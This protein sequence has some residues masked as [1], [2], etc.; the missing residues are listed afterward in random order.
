VSGIH[1]RNSETFVCLRRSF[2][3]ISSVLLF[4]HCQTPAYQEEELEIEV[5]MTPTPIPTAIHP[6]VAFK[7]KTKP[8]PKSVPVN[9]VFRPD[10][11][12]KSQEITSDDIRR[13]WSKF[14]NFLKD[15]KLTRDDL[16]VLIPGAQTIEEEMTSGDL[17]EASKKISEFHKTI[18]SIT[19]D[20]TFIEKK[21]ERIHQLLNQQNLPEEEARELNA[22]LNVVPRLV[23]EREYEFA[24]EALNNLSEEIL[25]AKR[26]TETLGIEEPTS[27]PTTETPAATN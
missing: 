12:P 9:H 4:T 14:E 13:Q 6:K 11:A 7:V 27:P 17:E 24:N 21:L 16:I 1:L 5:A 18:E 2:F 20:A 15:R 8:K 22:R 26:L 23:E 10:S 25:E 19:I 3:L